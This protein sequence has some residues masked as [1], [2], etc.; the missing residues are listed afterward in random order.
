MIYFDN[1][2]TTFFKPQEALDGLKKA[3]TLLPVNPNRSFNELT[4]ELSEEIFS[5][6][7][8]LA[9]MVGLNNPANV[10]FGQNCTDA[11]NLA[12]LGGIRVKGSHVITSVLEHNSVLR[13]LKMLERSGN[14]SLT[15]LEPDKNMIIS[16]EKVL[17]ALLPATRM[18]VLA[19]TSNVLG[20]TQPVA[21]IGRI[22]RR[23]GVT[24]VIDAA[25]SAGY[26][27]LNMEKDCVDMVALPAHKGLHGIAGLGALCFNEKSKPNPIRLGG[28]G[29][30]SHMLTQPTDSPEGFES[31][32]VNS[33]AIL[34]LKGALTWWNSNHVEFNEHMKLVMDTIRNGL[35]N[36]KRIKVLSVPNDSGIISF[37]VLGSDSQE[38]ADV[39]ARDYKIATRGG[40]HC[41]PLCHNFLGTSR[42]GLVRI[43]VS[44]E[45]TQE[46]AYAF[47]NAMEQI[48]KK[49]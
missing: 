48:V 49:I 21:E 5:T 25:Q 23:N 29:T 10:V 30:Q 33:P 14:I 22:C 24:F 9:D 12:I 45:N 1:A 34:A 36:V 37:E 38:I 18:V 19:Q 17:N 47:L 41:A 3:V 35:T 20:A 46:E 6:R 8:A 4:N 32:T 42:T 40:L 43:S 44:G 7:K 28:T 31:G 11:L 39:L 13:P 15:V 2:A 26:I 27:P 16:P